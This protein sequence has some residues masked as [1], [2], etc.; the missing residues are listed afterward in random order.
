M[1]E[2]LI[3][4]KKADG[5]TV[6]VPF[7][8]VRK[9]QKSVPIP[10]SAPKLEKP[11]VKSAPAFSIPIPQEFGD[12]MF[13]VKKLL[14]VKELPVAPA[15]VLLEENYEVTAPSGQEL[16]L[17]HEEMQ[18]HEVTHPDLVAHA[19]YEDSALAAA[20]AAKIAIP[21][22]LV[23][24]FN[25]LATSLYKGVRTLDQ[26]LE[27]VTIDVLRGGLGLS[28][29]EAER[30]GQA[31]QSVP[32]TPKLSAKPS[33][34]QLST[35]QPKPVAMATAPLA[36]QS[37]GPRI[38]MRDVEA[39]RPRTLVVMGPT[40][41]MKS[42]TITDWRR[43]AVTP[44]KAKDILLSKFKGLKNESYFIYQEACAAWLTSPLL[45]EYQNTLV[46]ALNSGE[47]LSELR[48]V[49][50]GAALTANDI[51]AIVEINQSLKV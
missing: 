15:E 43:L 26:F 28:K 11:I 44:E 45:T 38:P 19:S 33:S 34:A 31:L 42:F 25:S 39:P 10:P 30:L 37:F 46:N 16:H 50:N 17:L 32:G 1:A 40:E 24:R 36:G 13:E 49:P 35:P 5:T 22:D 20:K 41:E 12:P 14:S 29:A 4:V 47:R 27:Y 48:S 3:P 7:S 2:P 18:P 8:E 51:A 23:S 21:A 9:M 6:M